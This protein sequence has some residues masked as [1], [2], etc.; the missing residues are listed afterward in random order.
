MSVYVNAIIEEIQCNG[1]Y[2]FYFILSQKF[3]FIKLCFT[4]RNISVSIYIFMLFLSS[5][6]S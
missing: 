1:N 2:Y 4:L 3:L 6:S 5:M